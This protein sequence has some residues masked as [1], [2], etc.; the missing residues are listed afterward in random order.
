[1]YAQGRLRKVE[2]EGDDQEPSEWIVVCALRYA[3][4]PS[5]TRYGH[6]PAPSVSITAIIPANCEKWLERT[7][8]RP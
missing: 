2:R 7:S 5:S 4:W 3:P 1:M 6:E 8:S